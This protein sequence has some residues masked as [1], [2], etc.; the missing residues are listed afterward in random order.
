MMNTNYLH[1][2]PMSERTLHD[3]L[4]AFMARIHVEL[5]DE[6]QDLD[7]HK[8]DPRILSEV[9]RLIGRDLHDLHIS[10]LQVQEVAIRKSREAV[11]ALYRA[12]EI[13]DLDKRAA[14]DYAYGWVVAT[15]TFLT[16]LVTCTSP[17][18]TNQC[19]K[20]M[21]PATERIEMAATRSAN[22]NCCC[23][24]EFRRGFIDCVAEKVG[25]DSPICTLKPVK[26]N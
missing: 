7:I 18:H 25:K 11:K 10:P 14:L 15:E 20:D 5:T 26:L 16:E 22:A 9:R 13:L 2:E 4:F 21:C 23:T 6:F 8:F 12:D 24:E 3:L 19:Q 1:S 17:I